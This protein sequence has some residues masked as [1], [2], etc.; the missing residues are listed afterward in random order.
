MQNYVNHLCI[1]KR[2]KRLRLSL[3]PRC[4][5]QRAERLYGIDSLL[6][7]LLKYRSEIYKPQIS[8][9][10]FIADGVF[11]RAALWSW[12]LTSQGSF[13]YTGWTTSI[14]VA[15]EHLKWRDG[16]YVIPPGLHLIADGIFRSESTLCA[17]K[18]LQ[19]ALGVRA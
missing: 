13:A 9:S 1:S 6:W 16:G 19:S 11:P 5:T 3:Q 12:K 10:G 18:I 4:L 7:R 15:V 2:L 17:F 14:L 8:Q